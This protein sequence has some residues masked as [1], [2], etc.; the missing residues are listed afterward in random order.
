MSL[1]FSSVPVL[2]F[3]DALSSETKPKFLSELRHALVD[4]GFFY[5]S[6]PS[7]TE[8][9][10]SQFVRKASGFFNL[11][12]TVKSEVGIINCNNFKGTEFG[13]LQDQRAIGVSQRFFITALTVEQWPREDV[14]PNFRPCIESYLEQ[15]QSVSEILTVLVAEALDLAPTVFNAFF[16]RPSLNSLRISAYPSPH[17]LDPTRTEFQGVGPHK[18]S[19]FLTYLLQGTEHTSLEVQTKSGAWIPVPPLANTLV[20][21][22]GRMLESLTR[23]V[24][25]ATTH[26]VNLTR[27]QFIRA[28]HGGHLGKRISAAFFQRFSSNVTQM[29]LTL[30]IP[31]HVLALRKDG[32]SD[33][34]TFLQAIFETSYQSAVLFNAIT[35]YPEVGRQWYP[36]E[37]AHALRKQ[38]GDQVLGGAKLQIP[39]SI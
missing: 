9:T 25:V 30:D 4:I 16:T 1:D 19:S 35:T 32:E 34:E 11:P 15:V 5:L 31:E 27:E 2:N 28:N 21:N 12:S 10:R 38:A 37:L 18:D 7:V 8:D 33:A 29:Q 14:L 36:D 17:G 23:G 24:C 39:A 22:I 6:D 13:M 3:Q 26:R 20:I